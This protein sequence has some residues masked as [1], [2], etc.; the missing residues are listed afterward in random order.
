MT[1]VRPVTR[2]SSPVSSRARAASRARS[3]A[4]STTVVRVLSH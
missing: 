3:I 1:V 2:R 4:A